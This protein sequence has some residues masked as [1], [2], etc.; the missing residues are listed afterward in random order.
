MTCPNGKETFHSA[1]SANSNAAPTGFSNVAVVAALLCA[2][3]FMIWL[4]WSFLREPTSGPSAADTAEGSAAEETRSASVPG[5]RADDFLPDVALSDTTGELAFSS[6]GRVEKA[7]RA[8][9]FADEPSDYLVFEDEEWADTADKALSEDAQEDAQSDD[10]LD[11]EAPLLVISGWVLDESGEPVSGIGVSASLKHLLQA[12]DEDEP[13][14]GHAR[15]Q[16]AQTDA[17]GFF[18]FGN[19]ADGAYQIRSQAT[20]R[21]PTAT[22]VVRAGTES[23]VLVV[24]DKEAKQQRKVRVYG[25]VESSDGQPLAQ[26]RVLPLGQRTSTNTDPA[27]GYGFDLAVKEDRQGQTVKFMLEGYR[28]QSLTLLDTDL[29]GVDSSRLDVVMEPLAT[30]APVTGILTDPGGTPVAGAT[31]RLDSARLGRQYQTGSDRAGEFSFAAVETAGDYRVWVRPKQDYQ[32]YFEE[33]LTVGAAGLDLDILLDPQGFASLSGQ[34]VDP[35]G[36]PLPRFSLWL[37]S[38]QAT[39]PP[40]LLVTGDKRG[41]FRVEDLPAGRL[42]L[43]T[44]SD[45]QFS[46]SGLEISAD[47]D[48]EVDLV[49]DWGDYEISG[50]VQNQKGDPIARSRVTLTWSS[51]DNGVTSHSL[52]RT[53][54]D[55]S[56]YFLFTQLGGDLH[57]LSASAPGYRGAQREVAAAGKG[58][59]TVLKLLEDSP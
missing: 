50:F 30:E 11:E 44:R 57:K 56:G 19:L 8:S 42:S 52:R 33:G 3:I 35:E 5:G 1:E 20:E 12:P 4:S 14:A 40:N 55:G 7:Q 32:D 38:A 25:R 6:V 54:S 59:T 46:I 10:P 37:R 49:L 22:S 41:R 29:E 9:G 17:D 15:D 31:I 28:N 36:T 47:A 43:D 26:V 23:A 13:M 45:P 34:M 2:G 48:E 21:Y 16:A 51:Y 58:A 24:E 27:G 53:T 18:E 39:D